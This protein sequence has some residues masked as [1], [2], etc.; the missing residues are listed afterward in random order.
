MQAAGS[1]ARFAGFIDGSWCGFY[2]AFAHAK[3]SPPCISATGVTA[4]SLMVT[5]GTCLSSSACFSRGDCCCSGVLTASLVSAAISESSSYSVPREVLKGA[6]LGL[7]AAA[8]TAAAPAITKMSVAAVR[9][10]EG[11]MVG[12][13]GFEEDSL[14]CAEF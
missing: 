8:A 13:R 14:W 11:I 2:A 7:R 10:V 3:K 6:F 1:V 5:V 12:G 4:T 9:R